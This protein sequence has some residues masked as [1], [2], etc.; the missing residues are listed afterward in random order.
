M[1]FVVVWIDWLTGN[2][3]GLGKRNEL[4]SGPKKTCQHE[5]IKWIF[6]HLR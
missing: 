3:I 2:G 6:S 5:R 4:I 1:T